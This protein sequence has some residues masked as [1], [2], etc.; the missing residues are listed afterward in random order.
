MKKPT[1]TMRRIK[2]QVCGDMAVTPAQ[3]K[4]PVTSEQY[5]FARHLVAYLALKHSSENAAAVG[6]SLG[7]RKA[8]DIHASC[9]VIKRLRASSHD[10]NLIISAMELDL[11]GY[12]NEKVST[13]AIALNSNGNHKQRDCMT[14]G[15]PFVSEHFGHRQCTHCRRSNAKAARGVERVAVD[16]AS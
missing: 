10:V 1:Y 3:I 12:G 5:A 14:C 9:D 8:E 2:E 16:L 7:G 6:R 15:E 4:G 11:A 13:I